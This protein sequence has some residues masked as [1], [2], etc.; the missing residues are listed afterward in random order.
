MHK[1]IKSYSHLKNHICSSVLKEKGVKCGEFNMQVHLSWLK[2]V[3]Y[4]LGPAASRRLLVEQ[5]WVQN[6]QRAI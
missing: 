3:D 4:T 5:T 1:D 6:Q 2:L